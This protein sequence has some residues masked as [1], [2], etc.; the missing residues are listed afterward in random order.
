MAE[1]AGVMLLKNKGGSDAD[2]LQTK[3]LL[4]TNFNFIKNLICKHLWDSAERC[5]KFTGTIWEQEKLHLTKPGGQR[6][7]NI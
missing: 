6:G 4:E 7:S 1:R 2:K 5:E 3:V